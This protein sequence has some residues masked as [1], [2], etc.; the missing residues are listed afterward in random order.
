MVLHWASVTRSLQGSVTVGGVTLVRWFI[1]FFLLLAHGCLLPAHNPLVLCGI[2]IAVKHYRYQTCHRGGRG[3]QALYAVHSR[4]VSL[5]KLA[6]GFTLATT[7][8]KPDLRL[9]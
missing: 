6:L 3:E 8:S 7:H 1:P 4:A 2:V 9:L 5:R